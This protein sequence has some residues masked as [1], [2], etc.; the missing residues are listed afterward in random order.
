MFP[1]F[2]R[3]RSDL[4]TL[5]GYATSLLISKP[6]A[7]M[8]GGQFLSSRYIIKQ[9][10]AKPTVLIAPDHRLTRTSWKDSEKKKAL[11]MIDLKL[12]S[13]ETATNLKIET[14]QKERPRELRACRGPRAAY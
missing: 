5:S 10:P 9:L 11:N 3:S 14:V 2:M 7:H 6:P 4:Q 12:D 8:M 13:V 1:F